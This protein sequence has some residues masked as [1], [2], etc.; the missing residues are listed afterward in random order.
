MS[1]Q[2]IDRQA[3]MS[4]ALRHGFTLRQQPGGDMD[5]NEH[6]Y[7]FAREVF[8]AGRKAERADREKQEPVAWYCDGEDGREYNGT[9]KMSSGREGFPLYAAPVSDGAWRNAVIDELVT[10]NIVCK[11][12]EDDPR[13]AVRDCINYNVQLALD[14][15][16]SSQAQELIDR[17]R[18]EERTKREEQEPVAHEYQG[19]DGIWRGFINQ[20][21][22][23]NTV[24]DGSWPIRALYAA[25][26][27][28]IQ[29]ETCNGRGEIGGFQGGAVPGYVT[30][31]CPDCAGA[32]HAKQQEAEE[33]A[34]PTYS[35]STDGETFY[36]TFP[37]P[38]EAAANHLNDMPNYASIEVGQNA[39][40]TAHNYVGEYHIESLLEMVAE[41]AYEECGD[42]AESWLSDLTKDTEQIK[43]LK[44]VVGDWIQ[45]KEPPGFWH[46]DFIR[47]ITRAELVESG[48]LDQPSEAGG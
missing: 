18:A 16:I 22:Y 44:Q 34:A 27:V 31:A 47:R 10:L 28:T 8:E 25:P 42:C 24:E 4:R 40:R 14:P 30:E 36:G 12:H 48:H 35:Y 29:C 21:H 26:P 45:R 9:P 6:V 33:S 7:A 13:L 37:T 2:G 39:Q 32:G 43:E 15:A 5:L 17:G 41:S 38:E 46:V 11:K 23:K 1:T 20:Q 19:R 3:I